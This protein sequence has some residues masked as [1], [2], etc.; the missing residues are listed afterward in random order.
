MDV[1]CFVKL[2]RKQQR[3]LPRDYVPPP[4]EGMYSIDSEHPEGI[5]YIYVGC[6]DW[7]NN[8]RFCVR[9]FV[10]TVFHEAMHIMVPELE[11][12]IQYAEKV[13]AKILIT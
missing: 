3:D 7:T 13:L 6:C 5:I 12:H 4:I 10:L 11:E 8:F 9:E 1:E 2:S